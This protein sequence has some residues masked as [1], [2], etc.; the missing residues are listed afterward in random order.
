VSTGLGLPRTGLNVT[1]L[2]LGTALLLIGL[3]GGAAQRIATWRTGLLRLA[4]R[5]SYEIYLTHMFV[6]IPLV[7][8]FRRVF[9]DGPPGRW[10]Y[11]LAYA[12]MLALAVLLGWLVARFFSEPANR[13]L[14]G[15]HADRLRAVT[16]PA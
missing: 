9:P 10:L 7:P 14:R 11:P 2:E 12:L 3:A 4:G 1:A 16:V 5:C 15:R 13:W 8:L 6:V